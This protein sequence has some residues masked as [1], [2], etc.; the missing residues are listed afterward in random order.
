M[1]SHSAPGTG[2]GALF[3][4]S[5]KAPKIYGSRKA[6]SKY[7]MQ[8]N[9]PGVNYNVPFFLTSNRW[10]QEELKVTLAGTKL[11]PHHKPNKPWLTFLPLQP[12]ISEIWWL[13]HHS[14]K[15][16]IASWPQGELVTLS[17][18]QPTWCP[19]VSFLS[20]L[21]FSRHCLKLKS[22]AQRSPEPYKWSWV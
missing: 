3:P 1:E 12:D 16:A 15:G 7:R 17:F 4:L 21:W 22:R 18:L 13:T 19:P 8:C 11:V 9:V 20:A 5:R 14:P 6:P 10:G 2:P